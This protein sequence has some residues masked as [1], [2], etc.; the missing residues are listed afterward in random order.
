MN[1]LGAIA[2]LIGLK[3]HLL[4]EQPIRHRHLVLVQKVGERAVPFRPVTDDR[5]R[6]AVARPEPELLERGV[7]AVVLRGVDAVDLPVERSEDR[8]EIGHREDHPVGHVELAVV[9]IDHHAQVV[10]V[11]LAREHHRFPDRAFLHFPVAAKRVRVEARRRAACERKSLRDRETLAHRP[12]GDLNAGK[13]RPGMS[14]QDARERSRVFQDGSIDISE[15]RVNRGQRRHRVPLA[16]HEEILSGPRRVGD[17]DI[18]EPAVVERDER[19]GR[20]ERA[21]G[22]KA[23]VDGI[24]ALLEREQPD[25]GVF[26]GQQLEN[27]LPEEVIVSG[28]RRTQR[29]PRV[30]GHSRRCHLRIVHQTGSWWR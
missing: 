13:D 27:A 29:A 1:S 6:L 21:A 7:H 14:V 30:A 9:A 11:L 5:R 12:G 10:Q 17:V 23:L 28:A 4:L 24:A 19:D 25:V 22:V 3:R 2:P 16:E 26:D 20:R 8:F 15:L 18:D